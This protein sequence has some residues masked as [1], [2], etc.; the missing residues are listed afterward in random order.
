MVNLYRAERC[1]NQHLA[2]LIRSIPSA[3]ESMI[4]G[5][6]APT[7]ILEC[8][9]SQSKG[10]AKAGRSGLHPPP[11]SRGI[12]HKSERHLDMKRSIFPFTGM[13]AVDPPK[14]TACRRSVCRRFRGFTLVELLVV[15]AVI[16]ILIALLLPAVQQAREAARR[17][18]CASN[19]KQIALA[20]QN[21][22]SSNKKLPA[23]GTYADPFSAF[24]VDTYLRIDLKTG[25]N[26]SWIVVLLPYLE[27]Q[28]IYDQIDFKRKVTQNLAQ[29]QAAQP[30]M[31]LCPSDAARGRFFETIETERTSTQPVRFGKTNYAAYSNPFHVDSWFFSGA[32][33]LYGRR[34][35]QV[36]DGTATTL[37]FA[38]IRTRD[39]VADQRGAG[40]CRGA[41]Q[42]CF[43]LIFIRKSMGRKMG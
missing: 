31:L 40:P 25:T 16:G 6:P 30:A 4:V 7:A 1:P 10:A 9:A 35:D 21:Y 3:A 17:I 27:E 28:A 32:I 29:P 38:E 23:A 12:R 20:V 37:A 26:Y 11:F 19:I 24:Y 18:Q 13:P 41:D 33:W 5:K 8:S 43:R 15:I 22:E 14:P 42:P 34:L 39:H 2:L 36:I